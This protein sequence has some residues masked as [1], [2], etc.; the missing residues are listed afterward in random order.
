MATLML[1]HLKCTKAML[2]TL[3]VM[4]LQATDWAAH[5][6]FVNVD[7]GCLVHDGARS[8]TNRDSVLIHPSVADK[9]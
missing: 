1:H 7:D 8:H 5:A 9:M 3:L 2:M 6:N 4:M